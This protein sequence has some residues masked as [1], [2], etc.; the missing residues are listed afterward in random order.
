MHGSMSVRHK[1][2]GACEMN[3]RWILFYFLKRYPVY[4]LCLFANEI[5][6]ALPGYVGNVLFLK[7]MMQA[8]EDGEPVS[9]MML[10]LLG[11][12]LFLLGS[13]V[14]TAWFAGRYKPCAEERI[15]KDFYGCVRNAAAQFGLERYDDP[16]FYDEM[17]Y[18]NKNI[19]TD[20]RTVLLHAGKMTAGLINILLIVQL[21]HE[22]G[23]A[24]LLFSVGSAV[25]SLS[26]DVPLI[27]SQNKRKYA[28]NHIERKRRYFRDCFF[29]R[30]SFQERKMTDVNPR[31]HSGY[32]ESVK[33]QSLCEKKF[34]RKLFWL[35]S[36]KE[37]LPTCF[38]MQLS[39]TAYLLYQV[40]AVKT[41]R[42]SDFVAA[43]NGV[44]VVMGDMMMFV[45]CWSRMASGG[46]TVGKYRVFLSSVSEETVLDREGPEESGSWRAEEPDWQRTQDGYEPGNGGRRPFAEINSIAFR[47]VSFSYPG[48]GNYAGIRK[49]VLKNISFC[50]RSGEKTAVVGKNGSGKTTLVHLLMGLY[51][52]TEGE[53][54]VNGKPLAKEDFPLYRHKFA[55]FFQGMKPMEATAAENVALDTEIDEERMSLAL[56]QTDCTALFPDPKQAMIGVQFDPTGL[57]LS[58]GQC[59]KLM[60]AHCFYSNKPVLVM[61]EPS[62]ALD[63]VLEQ[64]FNRQ[65]AELA[66]DKLTVFVTHRLSTVHMADIIYV[67]EDGRLCGM[68]RHEE[69]MREEGVYADMWRIQMEKYGSIQAAV[70]EG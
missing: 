15:Q 63:P 54:L 36:L 32:E 22:M 48:S 38:L 9:R 49:D 4:V 52:P 3:I 67:I 68:G 18:V 6:L 57:I 65:V 5:L 64:T 42:G 43:Y 50:I 13:D 21:F 35:S 47:N 11:T 59:Q 12:F 24:V 61:D 34:G 33:E 66:G 30:E 46:Y 28:V 44:N 55:A 8:L 29:S 56:H 60:L 62:A 40:L 10:L 31:L 23:A 19:Y 26:F 17:T 70:R 7:Y 25:L 2:T 41:L 37:L 51:S 1:I 14:Y 58:G 53:I 45:Q 27:K 69:L 20:S 39:L 16:A